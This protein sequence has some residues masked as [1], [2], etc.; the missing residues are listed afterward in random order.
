MKVLVFGASGKTGREVVARA[1]DKGH[2]VTAFCRTPSK[3]ATSH[4][5]LALVAGDVGDRATIERAMPGHDAVI[6]TL[7][8]GTPFTHDQVVV[9]GIGH[10]TRAMP[11]SGA[12]RL[13]YLSTLGV[14]DSR[15]E[16]GFIHALAAK[17][18]PIRHEIRDHMLKE[19]V[20]RHS[21]LDW[22]IVRAPA[23]TNGKFTGRLRHGLDIRGTLLPLVSRADVAQFLVGQLEDRQYLRQSVRLLPM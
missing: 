10:I 19:P 4:A 14:E 17:Y 20:V 21:G 18:A 13:I 7:G 6:S 11:A 22:T 8:V 3:L 9:D 16:S 12:R 23:M 5:A 1:L 15:A 2:A